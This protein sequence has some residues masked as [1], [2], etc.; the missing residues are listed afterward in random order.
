M[1]RSEKSAGNYRVTMHIPHAKE[2]RHVLVV[3]PGHVYAYD[4]NRM[5][6]NADDSPIILELA[7]ILS[8]Q[9]PWEGE[10]CDVE[11]EGLVNHPANK[12]YPF[13]Y[14]FDVQKLK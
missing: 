5:R 10:L 13:H 3:G 6:R 2:L 1:L 12:I 4:E 11:Y 7:P 8:N 14:E 9:E